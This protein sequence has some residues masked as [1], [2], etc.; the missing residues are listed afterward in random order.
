MRY[1]KII[2]LVEEGK[3]VYNP[4]TGNYDEPNEEKFE[5]LANISGLG[6]KSKVLMFGEITQETLVFRLKGDLDDFDYIEYDSTLYRPI[7]VN[8]Y[9]DET[10][11]Y[12][13]I[14]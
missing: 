13:V 14:K 3:E 10:V 5:R 1:E 2:Y 9:P 6:P 11:I 4:L 7:E 12:G 8:K